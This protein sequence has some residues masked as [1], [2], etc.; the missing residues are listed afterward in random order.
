MAI[1]FT[2]LALPLLLGACAGHRANYGMSEGLTYSCSAGP[3]RVVYNDQGYLP[4]SGVRTIGTAAGQAPAQAP[5]STARLWYGGRE[6]RLMADW[7]ETGLRYRSIEPVSDS[8]VLLW[9]A[10]GESAWIGEAPLARGGGE[11]RLAECSRDRTVADSAYQSPRPVATA[12]AAA[13]EQPHS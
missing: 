3:A 1:A 12:P 6:Y 4:G 9:W 13:A 11:R 7:A 5:R 8:H 10:D 2:S